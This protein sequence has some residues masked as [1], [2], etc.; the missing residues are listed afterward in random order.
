MNEN[1]TV[2]KATE[3]DISL[4]ENLIKGLAAYEKKT[5]GYDCYTGGF[6]LSSLRKEHSCCAYR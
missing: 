5:A 6:A 2:R 3:N 4:I 1:F